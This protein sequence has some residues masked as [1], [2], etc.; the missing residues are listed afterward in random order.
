MNQPSFSVLRAVCASSAVSLVVGLGAC[1]SRP[2]P[3]EPTTPTGPSAPLPALEE[4]LAEKVL[5]DPAAPISMIEYSSLTCSY[6]ADFHSTTLPLIKMHYIDTGKVRFMYRDFPLD[7]GTALSAS[8]VGRCSGDQFFT[9]IDL[10]YRTQG[11]WAGSSNV[12][13]ALKTIVAPVG[14]TAAEVNTCLASTELRNGILAI[15]SR[16]QTEFGV[17]MTPTF[18]I[19]GQ[20]VEGALP[21]GSFAA[22][23]QGM[24]P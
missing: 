1:G 11:T 22:I 3:T 18:L 21:Y 16:G 6:C 17:R 12:A 20:K 8:M 14:M 7:N 15:R 9:V 2:S 19:N 4:M 23:F 13:S 5:G 24:L 10:L